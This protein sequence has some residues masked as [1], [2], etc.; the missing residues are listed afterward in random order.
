MRTTYLYEHFSIAKYRQWIYFG[1]E[2]Y[3]GNYIIPNE[4]S[5]AWWPLIQSFLLTRHVHSEISNRFT[6][7]AKLYWTKG[8]ASWQISKEVCYNILWNSW[9]LWKNSP[10]TNNNKQPL[11]NPVILT[12][13]INKTKQVMSHIISK[14]EQWKY[15]KSNSIKITSWTLWYNW[16]FTS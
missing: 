6:N 11:R 14:K 3:K 16:A 15:T 8:N 12:I 10:W 2:N 4:I 1:W 9:P 5:A 7:A 13:N